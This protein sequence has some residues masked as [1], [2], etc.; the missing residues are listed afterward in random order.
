MIL[1][2]LRSTGPPPGAFLSEYQNISLRSARGHELKGLG[3]PFFV[4]SPRNIKRITYFTNEF[5]K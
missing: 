3:Y 2:T 5:I 4:G 1:S